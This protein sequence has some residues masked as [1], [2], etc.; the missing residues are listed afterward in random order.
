[1]PIYND[2]PL[3]ALVSNHNRG[4]LILKFS[5][6]MPNSFTDEQRNSLIE[7]LGC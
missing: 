2:N 4:S 5:I 3:S 7:I 1:M 6:E